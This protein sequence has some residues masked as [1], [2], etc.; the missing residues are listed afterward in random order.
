MLAFGVTAVLQGVCAYTGHLRN[1]MHSDLLPA[2][3]GACF[4]DALIV[5][6]GDPSAILLHQAVAFTAECLCG[7][8]TTSAN[9][10]ALLSFMAF[11]K[12]PRECAAIPGTL[13]AV[14]APHFLALFAQALT[15]GSDFVASSAIVRF[16][17]NVTDVLPIGAFRSM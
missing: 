13:E 5:T 12:P 8:L 4:S 14:L 2:L 9:V 17:E 3:C 6:Y 7:Y 10:A 16:L 15:H 1:W 11:I